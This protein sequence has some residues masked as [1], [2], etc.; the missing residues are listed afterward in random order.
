MGNVVLDVFIGLVFLYLLYSLLATVLQEIIS[1]WFGLRA[2]MLHKALRR[3]LQDEPDT[4]SNQVA[5]FLRQSCDNWNRFF[6]PQRPHERF[7]KAFYQHPTIKYLGEDRLA[8][9]PSYLHNH[10]FANTVVHLLRGPQYDGATSSE[11]DLIG[12]SLNNGTLADGTPISQDTLQHLRMLMA[13][14]RRDPY[15]FRARLE[16][17]FDETMQRTTGW[18]KKQTQLIL[19]FVGLAVAINFN[20]D[21]IAIARILI[22]NKDARDNLVAFAASRQ[23]AYAGI[24][25]TLRKQETTRTLKA[26]ADGQTDTIETA[27]VY[28]YSD[29]GLQQQ[30][31]RLQQDHEAVQG[32][33]GLKALPDAC[34]KD[35]RLQDLLRQQRQ[36]ANIK[37][38]KQRI[39]LQGQL[40]AQIDSAR[41]A[42]SVASPYKSPP[43][44]A[45][46]GWLITAF[47]ISLGAPFWFDLLNKF[48]QLRG[49]GPKPASAPASPLPPGSA[50]LSPASNQ[51]IIKG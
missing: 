6:E 8:S 38:A 41:A 29:S 4:S 22:N 13:D 37:D 19:F 34:D 10:N 12:A 48:M 5:A 45:F 43:V 2:R 9:K 24:V 26:K 40:K 21:S 51:L 27:I 42:C 16:D 11:A 39:A 46:I 49:S 25:D 33:L 18:Y 36:A 28:Q 20:V 1:R 44:I 14:A 7:L 3:M 17:W 32:I 30:Y 23:Q 15:A 47:A 50:G 35:P 31:R